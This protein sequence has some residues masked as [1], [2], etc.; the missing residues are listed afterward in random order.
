LIKNIERDV[1]MQSSDERV[2]KLISA[3][4]EIQLLKILEEIKSVNL[5][6]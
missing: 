1:G 4:V 6:N 5:Q 3:A 2:H